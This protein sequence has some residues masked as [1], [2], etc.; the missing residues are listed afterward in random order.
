MPARVFSQHEST[1]GQTYHTGIHDLIGQSVLENPILVNAGF[2]SKGIGT[3]DRLISLNSQSGVVGDHT[4]SRVYLSG[5][6]AAGEVEV[7]GTS[8]ESHNDFFQGSIPTATVRL[9]GPD[10][11]FF[12]DSNHGTGPV[13]AMYEAINRIV[14]IP[15]DL[16]EFSINAVTEGIDAVG[17]VTIRI[18]E[19]LDNGGSPVNPQTGRK[20]R[21]FSGHGADTDIIVAS[22][23]AYVS[24]LNKLIGSRNGDY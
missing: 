24:A 23:K 4:T 7:L 11:D 13:D 10:G 21:I 9:R 12:V 5:N 20:R 2:V 3:Y 14:G 6:D 15:N 19:K 16:V 17:E 22:A 18:Q 8:V 1:L